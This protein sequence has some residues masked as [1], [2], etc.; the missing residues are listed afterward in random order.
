MQATSSGPTVVP[1]R[2]AQLICR[3][4]L[5]QGEV[6]AS[7]GAGQRN[8]DLDVVA[9][10]RNSDRCAQPSGEASGAALPAILE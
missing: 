10:M 6:V 1:R 3:L 9:E 4:S 5:S 8:S 2:G 7:I